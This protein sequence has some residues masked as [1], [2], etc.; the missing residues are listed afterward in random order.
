MKGKPTLS[1][2][3]AKPSSDVTSERR[4]LQNLQEQ[5]PMMAELYRRAEDQLRKRRLNAKSKNVVQNPVPDAQRLLHESEVHQIELEMQNHELRESRVKMEALLE[6]FTDF[7]DFAPVGYF[8]INESGAIQEVNL[9]GATMLGIGRSLL[10]NRRLPLFINSADRPGFLAFV[11][12]I[13]ARAGKHVCEASILRQDGTSFLADIQGVSAVS[14]RESQK[15][16][17]VVVS[18]MSAL[19]QAE[20]AQRRA[21]AL[22]TS[23]KELRREIIRR[24][25]VEESLKQ[26]DQHQA[27]LLEESHTMQE[28]LRHL[29]R[30]VLQAQEDERKRISRELHDVIAQTLTGINITLAALKKKVGLSPK[31]FDR[32]IERTQK[33]V[34]NSVNIVHQF[35][36]ELR[37]AVLDDLGLVSALHSF[38]KTFTAQT[39]IHTHLTAFAGLEALDTPRR[40]MLYRVAQEALTNIS[41]HARATQVEVTIEKNAAGICMQIH[42]NGQS[43]NV[44]QILNTKGRNRLGMLGM[45]ERLEMVGGHFEIESAPGKGT[46]VRAMIPFDSGLA[47]PVGKPAIGIKVR[48]QAARQ[49]LG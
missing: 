25:A 12:R 31:N 5:R 44:E 6:K 13:F 38:L 15:C 9:T 28:Q 46:T 32:D 34:E 36:R 17:W 21:D 27:R 11:G 8:S 35:A 23:N 37:P 10:I 42:D 7:Y 14:V 26:S 29:S 48:P 49:S 41:Q 2:T 4:E 16:C 39:G 43:F 3:A 45:R 47:E 22:A 20:E 24:Q 18:D 40:T 30:Q 19:K 33:L 1:G